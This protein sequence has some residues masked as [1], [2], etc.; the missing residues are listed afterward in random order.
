M[1]ALLCAVLLVHAGN[2]AP[3]IVRGN[4]MYNSKTNERFFIRGI[5][6]DYAVSDDNFDELKP[7]LE[8]NL[9]TMKGS[10]NTFRLYNVNPDKKYGKFMEYMDSIGV[11]VL[12]GAS[13]FND[14]YFTQYKYA[15]IT[16]D[17]GPDGESRKSNGQ[18]S[19]VKD[20]TKTCYPS[21]LLKYG[22]QVTPIKCLCYCLYSWLWLYS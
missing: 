15:T 8:T 14:P 5:A 7:I 18:I 3:I 21:L 12:I 19:L 13:P 11:Y 4:R 1:L 2:L 20:Q 6:Y 17:W 9:K 16:K 10:F 22:K